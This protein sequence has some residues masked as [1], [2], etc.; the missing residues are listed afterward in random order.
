M[1]RTID[2]LRSG[3]TREIWDR[4]CGFIDLS[5][6]EF[7]D[8]QERLLLEQVDWFH[9]CE[10]G[11]RL[12][13]ATAPTTVEAFRSSVPYTT[14]ADYAPY[15]LEKRWDVLPEEP[16]LWIRTSGRS[17]EYPAKWAP[18]FRRGWEKAG[19]ST[20]GAFIFAG[21]RQRY[22]VPFH[23]GDNVLYFMGPPPLG[24]GC[25]V[26]SL[27]DQFPFTLVP[28]AEEAE[29]LAFDKRIS[30]A[31]ELAM[32]DGIDSFIGISSILARIGEQFAEG[33]STGRKVGIRPAV[34]LRV[35]RGLLKARMS[36]RPLYPK[37][38]WNVKAI[39]TV[40]MDTEVYRQKIREY[41]GQEPLELYGGTEVWWVAYQ[42]WDREGMTFIPDNNFLE[43]IPEDEHLKARADP[44]HVPESVLLCDVQP[45][46][47]YEVVV[48]NLG[49][50][51]T[52]YRVGDM[53]RITSRRNDR[54]GID[55]PQ[56]RFFSRCDDVIDLSGFTRLTEQVIWQ[57]VE[58]SGVRYNDWTVCKEPDSDH[59]VLHLYLEP[60]SPVADPG[61]LEQSIR[62]NLRERD[63]DFC[64]LEEITHRRALRLTLLPTGTFSTYMAQKV[65]AGAEPAHLKPTHV[66]PSSAVLDALLAIA[67][68]RQG[69]LCPDPAAG[70]SARRPP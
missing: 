51:F 47:K 30:R 3:R 65:A 60:R 27:L 33:G 14:Y 55:I 28:S 61:A 45:G 17:G 29:S 42:T 6:R 69:D 40:G 32:S 39:L 52:R 36:H 44:Y 68:A 48:T 11:R 66:N 4:Y 63:S 49:G 43:F 37:D 31:F 58:A 59:T 12:L 15:F 1:T 21:A 34:L 54:L 26:H 56:M 9:G 53:I 35:L 18:I 64:D 8:I 5:L 50:P 10:L 13:G 46:Q 7:M 41:W 20:L 23:E 16:L 38:L 25:L 24:L 62:N 22:D 70:S 57:A 19:P 2:L 67:D